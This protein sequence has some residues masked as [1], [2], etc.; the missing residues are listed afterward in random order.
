MG[1]LINYLTINIG[2]CKNFK[3]VS[4]CVATRWCLENSLPTGQTIIMNETTI[5]NADAETIVA[6]LKF[7][8]IK[9]SETARVITV[10]FKKITFCYG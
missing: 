1:W 10:I 6:S 2:F 4:L 8:F 9:V 3:A 5:S 7:T